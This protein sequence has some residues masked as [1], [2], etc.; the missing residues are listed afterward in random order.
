METKDDISYGVV[1]YIKEGGVLKFL[2]IHQYSTWGGDYYWVFPKGHA[3]GDE[4]PEETAQRELHEET[5]L[6]L[7][8]LDVS[9][10]FEITYEFTID[11]ITTKK[12]SVF[13][14]GEATSEG[15]MLQEDELIDAAWLTYEK[16]REKITFENTK[17]L[18][19]EVV[20]YLEK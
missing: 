8:S 4:S 18:L 17:K 10:T 13:F 2:V 6:E 3:E 20:E 9:R 19:D 14:V 1:P 12:T 15:F 5:Q 7:K 11:G 16:A